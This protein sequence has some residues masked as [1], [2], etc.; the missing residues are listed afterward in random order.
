MLVSATNQ[1]HITIC[2][3]FWSHGDWKSYDKWTRETD[4]TTGLVRYLSAEDGLARLVDNSF[5]HRALAGFV[6]LDSHE[7]MPTMA[8]PRGLPGDVTPEVAEYCV[9][10]SGVS[11]S[12]LGL[13][14][15]QEYPW[16]SVPGGPQFRKYVLSKLRQI[17]KG[18]PNRIRLVFW[19]NR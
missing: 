7:M 16:N 18:R 1:R 5:I 12:W 2:V 19:F 10:S 9:Q 17:V 3:E 8:E 15:L 6:T 14:E 11:S 4:P 13:K